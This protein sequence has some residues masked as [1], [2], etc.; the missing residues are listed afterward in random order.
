[1][2]LQITGECGCKNPDHA[3]FRCCNQ[4]MAKA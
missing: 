2:E 4:E 3:H 1:M